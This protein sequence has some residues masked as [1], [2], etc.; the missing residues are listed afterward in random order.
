MTTGL[1]RHRVERIGY[2]AN[3]LTPNGKTSFAYEYF[4]NFAS[5]MEIT[6]RR[7]VAVQTAVL[8]VILTTLGVW[9]G[10]SAVEM[11]AATLQCLLSTA[12]FYYIG[13]GYNEPGG[14]FINRVLG[15]TMGKLM[16]GVAFLILILLHFN[17]TAKIF[18]GVYLVSYFL[19]TFFEV[20]A[21]LRNL[22]QNSQAKPKG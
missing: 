1:S 12:A 7:F 9:R 22:R 20:Y 5:R 3:D 14:K 19:F 15:A 6:L 16:L 2:S 13:A 4:L 11:G 8:A 10:F 18:A 17:V 21:L